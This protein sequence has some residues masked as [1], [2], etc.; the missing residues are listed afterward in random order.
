MRIYEIILFWILMSLSLGF[1][2][3]LGG[4]SRKKLIAFGIIFLKSSRC[5]YLGCRNP[6]SL[7]N[8]HNNFHS[9]YAINS[10]YLILD[11]ANLTFNLPSYVQLTSRA[12]MWKQYTK[13]NE[14]YDL[15]KSSL[16]SIHFNH[17]KCINE[18]TAICQSFQCW[19]I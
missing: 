10:K 8:H 7:P 1:K 12:C 4:N 14:L 16:W 13:H 2:P 11:S 17:V 6:R 18:C 19:W 15:E 3:F 9:T 5:V